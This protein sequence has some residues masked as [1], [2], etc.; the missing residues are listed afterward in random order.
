MFG[1]IFGVDRSNP[2][3]DGLAGASARSAV[4]RAL[5]RLAVWHRNAATRRVLRELPERELAD[6][7]LTPMDAAMEASRPFW[8]G[9]AGIVAER[10]RRS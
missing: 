5:A 10:A 1:A 7:G 4:G 2:P 6:I 8:D 3:F 9:S